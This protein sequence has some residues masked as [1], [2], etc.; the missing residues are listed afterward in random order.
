MEKG[1][2][3][4]GEP[5]GQSLE[6]PGQGRFQRQWLQRSQWNEDRQEPP[7]LPEQCLHTFNISGSGQLAPYCTL[8]SLGAQLLLRPP[9]SVSGGTAWASVCLSS[10]GDSMYTRCQEPLSQ[11]NDS[12]YHLIGFSNLS[13]HQNRFRALWPCMSPQQSLFEWAGVG[14]LY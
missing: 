5:S 6:D 9:E 10:P 4:E 2:D 13:D 3:K 12:D 7:P 14:S 11:T 8:E 1:Q